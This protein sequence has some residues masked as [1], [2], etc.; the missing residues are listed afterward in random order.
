MTQAARK[1]K[2][3]MKE[4]LRLKTYIKKYDTFHLKIA[5]FL[6][7]SIEVDKIFTALIYNIL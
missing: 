1:R 5:N 2:N 7:L 3:S 6:Y 4:I